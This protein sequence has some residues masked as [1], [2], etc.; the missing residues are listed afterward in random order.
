MNL[1]DLFIPLFLLIFGFYSSA[2]TFQHSYQASFFTFSEEIVAI[3]DNTYLIGGQNGVF[4]GYPSFAPYLMAVD[5]TGNILFSRELQDH[6]VSEVGAVNDIEVNHQDSAIYVAVTTGGC[7]YLVPSS[8]YRLDYL[9]NTIWYREVEQAQ[10]L[11]LFPDGSVV[12]AADYSGRVQ[13]YTSTGVLLWEKHMAFPIQDITAVGER[14]F[15]V[16]ENRL[17]RLDIEGE[18][19]GA[20][21][22][23][24]S[25]QTS[26]AYWDEN[27]FLMIRTAEKLYQL[28]TLL[29]LEDQTGLELFGQFEQMR[30]DADYCYLLGRDLDDQRIVLVLDKSLNYV[31]DFP[32]G[33]PYQVPT[34]FLLKGQ[35]MIVTGDEQ[36]DPFFETANTG[37]Y[38]RLYQYR[39]SAI[40][41]QTYDLDGNA[42]PLPTD[43]TLTDVDLLEVADLEY[44]GFCYF[45]EGEVYN[46]TLNDIRVRLSNQGTEPL[47]TVN[48]NIR[49][50]PCSFICLTATTFSRSFSNLNLQPGQSTELA[51]G[52]L[53]LFAVPFD[54][55]VNLCVWPSVSNGQMD[56]NPENNEVC[57]LFIVDD[58]EEV[59]QASEMIVFP[60]PAKE[61]L[62]V[63]WS[64]GMPGIQA[65]R[66]MD[67][68]GRQVRLSNW[69]MHS[70]QLN[71][72]IESLSAGAYLL[73]I[74]TEK[75]LFLQR[76]VKM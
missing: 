47:E 45:P 31:K 59:M 32:V 35:Q 15:V 12:V 46:Y 2:Q 50:D 21:D 66:V 76:F 22:F 5:S 67:Y 44:N 42:A 56:A 51:L 36:P 4:M 52:N 74:E 43:V 48:L 34:N 19:L 27:D 75:G 37:A 55:G 58:T 38:Q 6:W 1:K 25:Q 26:I 65:V 33:N 10:A 13:R 20:Y 41:L 11:A 68:L 16:G 30:F 17:A 54:N 60:N 3:N 23:E 62:W 61:Y 40:F 72:N 9:G 14:L 63:E 69:E 24:G 29:N 7:D 49:F 73:Q 71:L 8:F 64:Q 28:D 18:L 57:E 39:G 53:Q 70:G